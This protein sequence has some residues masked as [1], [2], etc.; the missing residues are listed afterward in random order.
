MMILLKNYIAG[1]N[2]FEVVWCQEP[3]SKDTGLLYVNGPSIKTAIDCLVYHLRIFRL[4]INLYDTDK[5]TMNGGIC[6]FALLGQ[7]M[8]DIALPIHFNLY[9]QTLSSF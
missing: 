4:F 3:N 1:Y 8:F 2:V 6:S 7:T 9:L 5:T